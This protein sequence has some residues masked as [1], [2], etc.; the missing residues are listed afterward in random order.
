MGGLQDNNT[1]IYKGS[2][3]WYRVIGGDGS[4][5]A[6][7]SLNDYII[8]GSWQRGNIL[9]SNNRGNSFTNSIT[10]IYGDAAFIAPFVISESNPSILYAG[11][12]RVFKTE[13][14]G[15]SWVAV[16]NE[17][18]GNEILSMSASPKN[19]D[20]LFVGTA[21]VI[22]KSS[23]YATRNGGSSWINVTQ[24]LP[25][26]YPMDIAIDPNDSKTVYVV[27]GGYGSGHIFK[28][29]NSG[30]TWRDIT[31]N[32]SDVPTLSVVIDPFN[33]D[34]IYIGNDLGVFVSSNGGETWEQFN[35]GLPEAVMGMDLNI[36]HS[37]RSLW[38]ATHGNGAY[39]RPLI[40]SPDFYLTFSTVDLPTSILR[41][42]QLSF[43]AKI[44]NIG[45]TT[46]TEEYSVT[47]RVLDPNGVEV[48]L[49]TQSFCCLISNQDTTIQF[50]GEFTFSEVG[51]Y[52][53][54]LIKNG[55]SQLPGSDTLKQTIKVF[56]PSTIA[57]ASVQKI[58]KTYSPI[59][60]SN[61][62]NGNDVQKTV[63][64]PFNFKYDDYEYNQIQISTNGWVEFGTEVAGT[65]RGLSTS[66]QIGAIGANEN[67]RMASTERPTKALGPWW[68]D[69][70]ADESGSVKYT[71]LVDSSTRVFVIEW[72]DVRAYWDPASTTARVNFQV[73]LYEWTN[74]IEF[75]YGE[76]QQGT[77]DGGDIGASIGFKDHVGGDYHFFDIMA[78]ES[79]PTSDVITNLSPLTDWPG[80]NWAYKIE[81]IIT[82]IE[83]SE[84]YLPN[85]FSLEQ[86]YPNPFNPTTKIKYSIP[87]TGL[88]GTNNSRNNVQ[89][90]VY[91]VLGRKVATLVNEKQNAGT[92][93]VSFNASSLTSGVYIYK[94][95][96]GDFIKSMKMLLLK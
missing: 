41:Y 23:I 27:F 95:Q 67:G 70:N 49:D 85:K 31:G 88:N 90:I 14:G 59:T 68:E 42:R 39:R 40:Y 9:R 3:S 47:A 79:L 48:Y 29:T 28:T 61:S 16:S 77:F 17:L 26:R 4:W 45:S 83:N 8:Y 91:D 43:S 33:S 58:K 53:F 66:S 1:V 76:V 20:I 36:A 24:N 54:E 75:C 35:D 25:D 12:M 64:L 94:L 60:A 57:Y 44:S 15:D 69:L 32:L 73:R 30:E 6:I 10:G 74:I 52:T 84:T 5:S 7:N 82:D 2:D 72:N 78:N 51:S 38:V 96:N 19:P 81:T 11:R 56:E 87:N 65:E 50:S 86:N 34:Y 55:N 89:L 80:N 21:P 92:Y 71:T 22:T 13:N 18:D 46:Q 62:F 93:E 63:T 37:N